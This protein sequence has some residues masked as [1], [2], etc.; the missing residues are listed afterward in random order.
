MARKKQGLVLSDDAFSLTS[1]IDV[2]FLLLIYFMFLPMK[3]EADMSISLPVPNPVIVENLEFPNEQV[4]RLKPDGSMTLNYSPIAPEILTRNLKRLKDAADAEK[5]QTIVTIIPD[6]DA[7]HQASIT[8]LN[9]CA[10]AGIK[11][12]SF[13]DAN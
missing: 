6:G 10:L 1:M 2:V 5:R 8:V 7:P 12:V 4:V 11:S 13:S 9:S 3:Q